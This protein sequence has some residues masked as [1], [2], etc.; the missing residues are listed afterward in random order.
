MQERDMHEERGMEYG[1][2]RYLS[3]VLRG[4]KE[5]VRGKARRKI[6]IKLMIDCKMERSTHWM[7]V[8]IFGYCWECGMGME[9]HDRKVARENTSHLSQEEV[10]GHGESFDAPCVQEGEKVDKN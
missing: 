1:E 10:E 9:N 2:V 4:S 6:R 7:N 8:L 5:S 3:F